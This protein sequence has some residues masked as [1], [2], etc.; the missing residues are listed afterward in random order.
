MTANAQKSQSGHLSKNKMMTENHK[1]TKSRQPKKN[2]KIKIKTK[3]ARV[4]TNALTGAEI[5]GRYCK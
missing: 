5:S 3:Y 4:E 2:K 1:K